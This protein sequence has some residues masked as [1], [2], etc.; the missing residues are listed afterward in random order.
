MTKKRN[1]VVV[2]TLIMAMIVSSFMFAGCDD[3]EAKSGG[4]I[5]K[6]NP[7]VVV[8]YNDQGLV[9]SIKGLNDD[10]KKIV[11]SYTD[12]VGKEAKVVIKDVVINIHNAGYL[13]TATD[14]AV[15]DIRMELED[16]SYIPDDK[17]VD[18]IYESIKVYVKETKIAANVD[19]FDE[20][21]YYDN[22]NYT[23]VPAVAPTPTAEETPKNTTSSTKDD[24]DYDNTN[25]DDSNYDDD[26]DY[27]V[28][29]KATPKKTTTPAKKDTS[30]YDDSSS[31]DDSD[32]SSDSSDYDDSGYDD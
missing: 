8:N 26:S 20:S 16:D 12:Y 31:S 27:T 5:L 32:Y 11:E 9:T 24:S 19:G 13:T 2:M 23:T 4:V 3:A 21:Q 10:G 7:Q 30:D 6:V 15:K 17:F 1:R 28:K 18:D 25:Y 29:K 14:G 22:S